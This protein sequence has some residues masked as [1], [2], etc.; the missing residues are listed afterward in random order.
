MNDPAL[1]RVRTG[2]LEMG[3][4]NGPGKALA[5]RIEARGIKWVSLGAP[6]M[7]TGARVLSYSDFIA[8]TPETPAHS[9]LES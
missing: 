7:S 1:D 8:G 5:H 2:A 3:P 9:D 4:G 6:T